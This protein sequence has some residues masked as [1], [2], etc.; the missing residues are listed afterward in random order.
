MIDVLVPTRGRPQRAR[1]LF[2]SFLATVDLADTRMI[3]LIDEDDPELDTY[4][5]LL[6]GAAIDVLGMD[7]TGD[8]TRA[9]NAGARRHPDADILGTLNDDMLIRTPGWDVMVAAAIADGAVLVYGNDLLQGERLPTSPFMVGAIPRALGWYALPSCE[10]LYIDDAWRELGAAT[11]R[12]R[13]LPDMVIEH[14]HPGAGKADWDEG[15]ER[16]NNEAV[17]ARDRAAFESWRTGPLFEA[18]VAAVLAVL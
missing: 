1:D 11:G 13:Y 2:D 6:R 5:Q 10:H 4:A 18:D 16:A 15:Y 9:T 14:I 3:F 7:E 12:M 8:L 17:T